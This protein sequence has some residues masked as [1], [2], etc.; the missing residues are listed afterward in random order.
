MEIAEF[1]LARI[2]EDEAVARAALRESSYEW[3]DNAFTEAV[4][5]AQGEGAVE[6]A[7]AHIARWDPAR[8][9]AECEAKRRII[10]ACTHE[11][12]NWVT[13]R[14]GVRQNMPVRVPWGDD[15]LY[16]D[17]LRLLALPFADHAAYQ[18]EW[19]PS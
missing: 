8:V 19:R 10:H 5:L 17:A 15:D 2:A 6:V 18:Q 4:E 7:T 14:P 16:E 12:E 13:V 3:S 1:L 11:V 9:L